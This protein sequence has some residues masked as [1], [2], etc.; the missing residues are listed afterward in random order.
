MCSL[1]WRI[2]IN[3]HTMAEIMDHFE[4]ATK[5]SPVHT[6]VVAKIQIDFD[7]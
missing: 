6:A 3:I 5:H 4:R 7:E 1:F 2:F